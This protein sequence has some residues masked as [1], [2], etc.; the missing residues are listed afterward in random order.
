MAGGAVVLWGLL[1]RCCPRVTFCSMFRGP[2]KCLFQPPVPVLLGQFPQWTLQPGHAIHHCPVMCAGHNKWSKVKHVKGPKDAARSVMFA[3]MAMM[4]R[5]AV[6]E[7]GPNPEFNSQ[8]ANLVEQC[9]SKNMPKASIEAAIKGAEKAKSGTYSLYE[10]RGPG[11][12]LL[13]IEVLT[14]N[15]SR[16]HQT[17]KYLLQKHGGMMCDGAL[18][19]FEKK[20]VVVAP[21]EG[22]SMD[23]ALELAVEAGAEDVRETEDEDEKPLLQF[24]CDVSELRGVRSAL[25]GLNVPTLSASLEFVSQNPAL[26]TLA[27]LETASQ[28][29]GVLNDCP[30]VM[31]VWDNIQAQE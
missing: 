21:G 12:S 28:L 2:Q 18:H 17:V 19:S 8:L 23:R 13:L 31:R 4:I 6:R 10:A 30:D 7:G 22:L 14:D 26:L 27:Q 16:T 9:R 1:P 15:N 20:G 24:V 11:G 3:K 5:V 29:L 25:E